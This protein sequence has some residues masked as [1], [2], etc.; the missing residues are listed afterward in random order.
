MATTCELIAK[1]VLGSNA[2]NVDFTSIPSTYTDLLVVASA[3]STTGTTQLT[4][5]FNNSSA[6][7]TFRT[8]Q[9]D[10]ASVYS[11]TQSAFG[12]NNVGY[13]PTSSSTSNTFGNMELHFPNYAGSSNKSVSITAAQETNAA[14]AWMFT[15]AGLWSQTAAINR[16]TFAVYGGVDLASG[17]SFYLYGI[18]K[19]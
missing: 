16:L 12:F 14:S 6:D 3:R 11:Y 19:A 2:A 4:V 15:S 9:S 17:S 18:T 10:G 5:A 7:Y 13:L 1:S 8:L